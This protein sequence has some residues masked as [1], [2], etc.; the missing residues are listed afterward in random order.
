MVGTSLAPSSS[1][2][3]LPMSTPASFRNVKAKPP[4]TIKM[5]TLPKRFMKSW[6]LSTTVK[7]PMMAQTVTPELLTCEEESSELK[8]HSSRPI[9]RSHSS[10]YILIRHPSPRSRDAMASSIS[11][12]VHDS[13]KSIAMCLKSSAVTWLTSSSSSSSPTPWSLSP[14]QSG[15]AHMSYSESSL[16]G[17]GRDVSM[18]SGVQS[19]TSELSSC[20]GVRAQ[21]KLLECSEKWQWEQ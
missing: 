4:P 5:S 11:S 19:S 17:S 8:P 10:T 15:N 6:T 16:A 9:R 1:R 2:V 21:L 12:V 14:P 13:P 20:I 7:P 18:S 3:E